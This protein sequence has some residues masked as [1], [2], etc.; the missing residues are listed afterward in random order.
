[1]T[2]KNLLSEEII[3][4]LNA[5]GISLGAICQ[6]HGFHINDVHDVI[7]AKEAHLNIAKVIA[8]SVNAEPY[9][10]WPTLYRAHQTTVISGFALRVTI[11]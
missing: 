3:A 11:R 9:M 6:K 2:I 7:N 5:K 4:M 10:L 1:M 8:N